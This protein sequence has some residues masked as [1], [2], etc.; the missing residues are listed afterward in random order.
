[1][2]RA[3]VA[4]A[5]LSALAAT[6]CIGIPFAIPPTR[7]EVGTGFREVE[8]HV[9]RPLAAKVVPQPGAAVEVA[10]SAARV[11]HPLVVAVGVHPLGFGRELLGRRADVGVGY[12]YQGGSLAT[13]HGAYLEGQGVLVRGWLTP[14]SV[15]RFGV[16]TQL[17]LLG[18][19]TTPLLGRGGSVGVFA[20]VAEFTS[21]TFGRV[22]AKGGVFGGH[23]GE[24]AIGIALDAAYAQ[25]DR[26]EV[27][28]LTGGLTLRL[29]ILGGF[30][31][32]WFWSAAQK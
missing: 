24:A 23:V 2:H 13:I 27:R 29:P 21:G 17:R 12:V 11:D 15:G 3:L 5:A 31:F 14:E 32:A 6:G 1:M 4:I 20:E 19:E 16:R 30:A 8:G 7:L 22:D 18:E 9:G 26:A 28:T 25:I 10:T